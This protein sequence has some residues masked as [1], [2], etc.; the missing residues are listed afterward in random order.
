MSPRH[1]HGI[2]SLG[3]ALPALALR[4]ETLAELRGVDP[5]KFDSGLGCREIALCDQREDAATLAVKAAR[6]ALDRWDGRTSDLGLLVVGTET[7]KDMSRP[8]SAFVADELGLRGSIRSFEAKHACYGGTVA[9]RHAVEWRASGASRG[10]AALVIAS[11]VALYAPEDPGE[12]TQG[13]GAVAM[14]IERPIHADVEL[15]SH[16]YSDPAFDFY[17]PVGQPYPLVDG[18]LSLDCYLRATEACWSSFV[19]DEGEAAIDALAAACFHVPFPKMVQK[20]VARL[21]AHLGWSDARTSAFFESKVVPTMHW[22]RSVGN[23]YTASLWISVVHALASASPGDRIGAFSYGSGFGSELLMLR[24]G[25][26]AGSALLR[27]DVEA[28]LAAR[29]FLS[30]DEYQALRLLRVPAH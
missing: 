12:P 22:N 6:R 26:T 14:V 2:A 17:R 1:D 21:G 30:A 27:E 25:A 13:G 11:D 24:A 20:A 28:D 10:K 3:L 18:K 7:A 23:A 19:A 9:L 5:N 4:V 15:V 16:A 29:R 8:L